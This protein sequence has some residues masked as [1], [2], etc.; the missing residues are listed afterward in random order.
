MHSCCKCSDLLSAFIITVSA[1]DDGSDSWS[2]GSSA[3]GSFRSRSGADPIFVSSHFRDSSHRS[4]ESGAI[5]RYNSYEVLP[6]TS[7]CLVCFGTF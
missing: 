1:G 4:Y 2:V 3:Y 7:E 6:P 5:K